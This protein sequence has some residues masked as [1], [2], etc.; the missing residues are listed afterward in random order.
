MTN[1]HFTPL[2]WLVLIAYFALTMGIGAWFYRRTRS[3]DGYT[4]GNRS[5]PGWVCGLSIF[6]TFLSSIS[7]LALPGKSFAAN[8]NAFV[9]SLSLPLVTWVAVRWFLPYYRASGEVSAYALLERRFGVWARI[10]ASAFYLLTQ[11]ARA[12]VVLY[13]MALPM[14]V[15]FGWDIY[16]ILIVT[17]VCVTIYSLSGG[18]LAVIWT[19]AIQALVLIS[20][21]LLCLGIMLAGVPGGVH[22][23]IETA[24]AHHK[25]SLGSFGPSLQESTF[26]VLLAYGL[27]MNVVNFGIDQSYVQRY[28]ASR[29]DA[30]ARRGLWLGG[31]LYVPVSAVFFFIGTTLYAYYGADRTDAPP[32]AI[33]AGA[34]SAAAPSVPTPGRDLAEVK[35]IVVR[36]QLLQQG[37]RPDSPAF[38]ARREALLGEVTLAKIGD[39]VFPHFIAAHL[40]PGITGFLIA[41]VFAAAMSTISTSLNSSATLLLTDYYA[42][43]VRPQA[44]ERARMRVLY[45]GTILWGALGTGLALVL[46][47]LTESALDMWWT[48]SGV[49]GGG[50]AGL[51]LL[52]MISRAGNP[53]AILAM[54]AGVSVIGWLTLPQLAPGREA[55]V[56]ASLIPVF[57][58]VT[59]LAV[60]G[61][62]GRLFQKAQT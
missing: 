52:G 51:F 43:F 13:L 32:A 17:G 60:G 58:T 8:W 22:G 23:V 9:F 40:P 11:I 15:I 47:R 61:A 7:Y 34:G 46:V 1:A 29:S 28:V 37:V 20:G 2:D 21:A 42:R 4:A 33:V 26:W 54:V 3:A 62:L 49:L 53:A 16:V 38:A 19:D 50:M 12:G 30:S 57:G 45:A 35:E 5:A 18:I 48:L 39:R 24:T 25:F 55:V 6:A 14:Q 44:P 41:A 27:T 31:L 56:H 10:Y 36:Q 59:I